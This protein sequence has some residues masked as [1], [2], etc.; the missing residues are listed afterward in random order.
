MYAET[1]PSHARKFGIAPLQFEHPY[2]AK[3]FEVLD[4]GAGRLTNVILTGT[5]GDGKTTLCHELW[6]KFGGGDH[7]V[8]GKNRD[9]YLP[10]EVVTPSGP[11]QLHFIFEFS[12][13][14]PEKGRPW[15]EDRLELMNRFVRSVLE[16]D[17]DEF[18]IIAANDGR[19]VHAWDSLPTA[20]PAKSLAP[21]IEELLANDRSQLDDHELLF[22]NLSRM[23]TAVILERALDCL[24]GRPEWSCFDDEADDLAFSAASPLTRNYRL[25]QDPAVRDRLLAL[26][27]LLDANGLHVP[28][29]EVLLL[30]VNALLGWSGASDTAYVATVDGLRNLVEKGLVH[31]AALY[32]N[33][34]GANL[35]E[36]RREGLMVFRHL[37]GLRI[38]HETTNLLDSLLIFGADDPNLQ[39]DY[40]AYVASDPYY[41][42][43]PEFERLRRLYLE[44]ED[45]RVD[46]AQEFLT[47]LVNERRRLFFRLPE[48][49]E[50]LDPWKLSVF[51]S[52]G[53]YRRKVLEPLRAQRPVDAIIL[54]RL[55]CGLNRIWSGMLA[56]ELDRLF[57][58]TGLDF[59]SAKV[60][61][62]YLY[63]V[64]LRRSPHGDEVAIVETEDSSPA[65][66][67]NLGKDGHQVDFKLRL[68]RYEFLSRV[69]QGALPS[70]F[71]KECNE[72]VLAFKSQVLTEYYRLVGN[73]SGPLSILTQGPH[74]ALGSRQLSIN[75]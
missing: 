55:V 65:L 58:S 19:L 1:L 59:S 10:L 47:V 6:S 13:W 7:R 30:L 74:G 60:S 31:E 23:S 50:R 8:T 51:P 53:S 36:R 63:E 28:I 27:D 61:D 26:A 11:K 66:R 43:N 34:F 37:G 15:P 2:R 44:A 62:I 9:N 45:E 46:G 56:G 41:S 3:L 4:P 24:L 20:A 21:S 67:V 72:D 40:A 17:P 69:A 38:G 25:L 42:D 32:S 49:D 54:Q 39:A 14:C 73:N 5:A 18:F 57:L 68:V 70:S 16:P 75:L 35:P 33:F 29:R 22:L 52:A 48:N 64:P 71:S 12:G